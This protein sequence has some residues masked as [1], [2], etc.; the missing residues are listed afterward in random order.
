MGCKEKL[1]KSMDIFGIKAAAEFLREER[2]W[3]QKTD[4]YFYEAF[5][6]ANKESEMWLDK[7]L[8]KNKRK[9]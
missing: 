5:K 8:R 6:K 7:V 1:N 9:E 3:R 2:E 4:K